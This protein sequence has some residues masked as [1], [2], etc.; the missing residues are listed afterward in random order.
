MNKPPAGVGRPRKR[1][2]AAHDA[3][4]VA[5]RARNARSYLQHLRWC[6]DGHPEVLAHFAMVA[7]EWSLWLTRN[8]PVMV[9]TLSRLLAA[10]QDPVAPDPE[11]SDG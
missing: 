6:L 11:E 2:F 9:E 10:L 5:I 8:Q 3:R 7:P 4:A 1:P